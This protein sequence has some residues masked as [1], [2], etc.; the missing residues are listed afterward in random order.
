MELI[1]DLRPGIWNAW[2]FMSVFILQML[3]ILLPGKNARRSSHVPSGTKRSGLEKYIGVIANIVWLAALAY[4]VF[5][6]L[7]PGTIW[8]YA[9]ILVFVT[10][11]AVL[12]LS[13]INFMSTPI[14]RPITKGVY[15]FSRH[16]MYLATFLICLGTGFASGSWAFIV[17][18]VLMI[19]CFHIEALL[20]E[21]FC[22]DIYGDNYRK[23][24]E[25]T[26]RWIGF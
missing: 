2:I 15:R 22:L 14:D 21:R 7:R 9:G 8:F 5:L 16:P 18:T 10:G 19:L 20:E 13:T 23:Y 3:V 24:M 25:N 6:P 12:I 17:L 11:L 4:S 1:P 26:S